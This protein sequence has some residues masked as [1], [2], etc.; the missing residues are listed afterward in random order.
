MSEK[1]KFKVGDLVY[2]PNISNKIG[3][4]V[5]TSIIANAPCCLKVAIDDTAIFTTKDGRFAVNAPIPVIYHATQKNY[6]W[7]SATFA[8]VTFEPPPKC[9][10]PKEII[11]AMLES[12]W[13]YI[14]CWASESIE[15]PNSTNAYELICGICNINGIGTYFKGNKYNWKYV[16]PFDLK[17]GKT[18]IDFVDGK[19]VLEGEK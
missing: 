18:I 12:G 2:Y 16:T 19:A 17:T 15:T 4:I 9:K 5:G 7:L 3:K 1:V 10:E 6:E 11:K 13:E 8:N 14:A